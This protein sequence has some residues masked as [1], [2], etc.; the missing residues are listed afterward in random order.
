MSTLKVAAINHPSASSGGLAISATGNV[1]GAGLDLIT[2]QSFSAV[3]SVSI[4]NC[5]SGDY[6]NYRV[7]AV[8]VSSAT[9]TRQ[10]RMRVGGVDNSTASSYNIR[11]TSQTGATNRY[12]SLN[13]TFFDAGAMDT[14][15]GTLVADIIGAAVNAS[16]LLTYISYGQD[17]HIVASGRHDV[18]TA[19][20][21]FSLIPST[22]T[23]TGNVSV[24]GYKK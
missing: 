22:G 12:A 19:Y 3:S 14:L 8:I 6:D 5:F 1:T 13:E 23:I 2:T 10:I 21:G 20:D 16:T 15:R 7:I 18:A 4:N 17:A 24:F 11:G 9:A